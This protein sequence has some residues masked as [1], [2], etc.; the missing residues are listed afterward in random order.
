MAFC[1]RRIG[2]PADETGRGNTPNPGGLRI[3]GSL[4][5]GRNCGFSPWSRTRETGTFFGLSKTA[6]VLLATA[7]SKCVPHSHPEVPTEQPPC[8]GAGERPGTPMSLAR[9]LPSSAGMTSAHLDSLP[10]RAIPTAARVRAAGADANAD[11][12]N[13]PVPFSI[14][15]GQGWAPLEAGVP[16][17]A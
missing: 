7:E 3:G 6:P 16:L 4:V 8:L 5:G 13:A 9:Q 10:Q 12:D 14:D 11:T 2:A 15:N 1:C 17:C